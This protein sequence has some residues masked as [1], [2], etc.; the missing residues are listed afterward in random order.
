M[1]FSTF[2]VDLDDTVYP[3]SSG[4]FRLI[5]QRIV[6]YM[7]EE[8][9]I[10]AEEAQELRLRLYTTYGTTLR[11]LSIERGVNMDEYLAYVHDVPLKDVL[12]PDPLL[13]QVLQKYPS[14]KSSLPAPIRR[15]P[16]GYYPPWSF[17]IVSRKLS[18]CIRSPHSVNSSLNPLNLY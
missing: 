18:M 6:Q 8:M 15:T 13:R 9:K 11:G 16:K 17:R 2:L 5:R 10:P 14:A 3:A 12:Q 4:V 7:V 1:A